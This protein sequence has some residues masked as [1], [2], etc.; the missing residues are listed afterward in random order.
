MK[1]AIKNAHRSNFDHNPEFQL[2]LYSKEPR[3]HSKTDSNHQRSESTRNTEP[4]L[5]HAHQRTSQK[6]NDF[7]YCLRRNVAYKA[8][9]FVNFGLYKSILLPILLY[10]FDCSTPLRQKTRK[11]EAFQMKSLNWVWKFI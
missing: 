5:D 3:N 11:L 2:I 4:E 10:G 7:L 1:L 9:I 6:A 8:N